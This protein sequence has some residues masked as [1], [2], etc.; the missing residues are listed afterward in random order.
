KRSPNWATF[1]LRLYERA[2]D[3][4]ARNVLPVSG[5]ADGG[6]AAPFPLP[7]PGVRRVGFPV[8]ISVDIPYSFVGHPQGSAGGFIFALV[9]S[10]C[11]FPIRCWDRLPDADVDAS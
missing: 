2:T 8:L 3:R 1:S 4:P 7:V 10:E 5:P 9:G 11:T 6:S